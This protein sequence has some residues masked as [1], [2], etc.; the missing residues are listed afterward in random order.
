MPTKVIMPQLGESVV[1]GTVGRWLAQEG[2][3]V[4]EYEPL[5]AVTTDKVDTEVPAPATGILLKIYVSEGQTVAAGTLLA[6]IGA[7]GEATTGESAAGESAAGNGAAAH[8]VQPAARAASPLAHKLA[9]EHGVDLGDV[10]GTGP[11]GRVTREDVE[12][13]LAATGDEEAAPQPAG[14][15]GV[16]FIS[17]AVGR[18]AAEMG[19]DLS[20]VVGT[21]AGGRVTKKDVLAYVATPSP[22]GDTPARSSDA[23][24]PPWERPGTGD[25][26]KPTDEMGRE[27]EPSAPPAARPAAAAKPSTPA[28]SGESD[29]VPMSAIRRSIAKHMVVSKQTSPHVT[30]VMEADL[31]RVVKARER[32]KGDF[33]RQGTR[34]TFTPFFLQ[35]IVAGLKAKPEANSSFTEDGLLVHRRIHL[36]MAVAIPDG[37]IVPVIRDA[38]EKSLLGLARAVNDLAERARAKKLAP[39]EAQGGTFTLT[40]HGTAGSLFATPVINQPQAGILGVGAIQKRPVV[41]SKGHP[42]L[43]DAED[44]LVIRP[45]AYLSFTF[46]HRVLDGQGADGF[47]AAVKAFLEDYKD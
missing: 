47:L 30:T 12:A 18:L 32:L 24:L 36:G 1:E 10:P 5:L 7:E 20:Q 2:Q 41:I 23:D 21:G 8:A 28:A 37:L 25:L 35:A 44:A 22:R 15:R 4:K 19:V 40:N 9:A 33:E 26:F 31:T 46:D 17:P 42:L 16:G 45:M 3:P 38:D 34:L 14:G 29:L 11:G 43:P 6:E 27:P 13:F 39:D